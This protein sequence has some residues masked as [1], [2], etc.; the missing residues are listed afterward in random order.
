M[1]NFSSQLKNIVSQS[2][3][4]NKIV[5]IGKGNSFSEINKSFFKDS[6]IINLNDS[7]KLIAGNITIFKNK[8]VA[9][10]LSN[11]GFKSRYYIYP[12]SIEL[13]VSIEKERLVR[14][15]DNIENFQNFTSIINDFN[16]R[17]FCL[18]D[19]LFLS[20]IKIAYLICQIK[21]KRF[22]TYLV[23]FDFKV[24]ATPIVSDYSGQEME[25]IN[26]LFQTQKSYLKLMKNFLN[27]KKM[28]ELLHVGSID[29]SD[30]HI[31]Q[32]NQV[33]KNNVFEI[34]KFSQHEYYKDLIGKVKDENY[35][36]KVS[37]LTNNHLGDANRL[38][39]MIQLSKNAGADLIKVQK[40]DVE[41]FYSKKH[42]KSR[43][44]SPFGNTLEDY[45][46][47]VE[48]TDELFEIL[49]A[50]CNRLEIGW[51]SSILDEPSL[52][53][54]LKYEPFL[55]KL[56]STISNHKDYLKKVKIKYKGD[57]VISTGFTDKLYEEFVLNS[58]LDGRNLF[59]LQCTSSY[60]TPPEACQI[61]V[62]RYYEELSEIMN[63]NQLIPGYSSHDI[64][65][66]GCMMSVA[67]GAKM[68]E[69]HVKLGNVDWVHFDGVALDLLDGSFDN[70]IKDINKAAL[71]CGR[72][73]KQI[74]HQEHHKYEVNKH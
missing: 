2:K 13:L 31:N 10:E 5:I 65:S 15:G 7:E 42:L 3:T 56:P 36:I 71:M 6:F 29:I 39:K 40:R 8:R 66:L 11:N 9:E 46:K 69:K 61:S 12:K 70:F 1:E 64:G 23:G 32:L 68:V 22:K 72:K 21:N 27:D 35:V 60:P 4:F 37:E 45:R 38:M 43:Y 17:E 33:Y 16:S 50:E 24:S 28:I 51:F 30:I 25:F 67:A 34:N 54:I 20:A 52:D 74:H 14:V 18:S 48:L 47:G 59:L 55:I 63:G 41:T 49:I 26:I 19:Y 73:T 57:L 44:D 58:F 53:Y 62:V